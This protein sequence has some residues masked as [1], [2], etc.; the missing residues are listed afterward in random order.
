MSCCYPQPSGLAPVH[1]ISVNW[2]QLLSR[3]YRR[4]E[5]LNRTPTLFDCKVIDY[6]EP[7]ARQ[8]RVEILK[9]NYR[10]RVDISVKS[11]DC[12]AATHHPRERLMKPT[13]DDLHPGVEHPVGL[14]ECL[15]LSA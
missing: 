15:D 11:D 6:H 3:A 13:F 14:E 7:A 10:R 2:D 1:G 4:T 12:K 9:S 5:V 8:P